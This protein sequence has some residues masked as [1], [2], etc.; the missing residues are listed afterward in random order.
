MAGSRGCPA[1]RTTVTAIYLDLLERTEGLDWWRR[2]SFLPN[3]FTWRLHT[4]VYT[5]FTVPVAMVIAS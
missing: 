2:G 3:T 4:V 5:F 1:A